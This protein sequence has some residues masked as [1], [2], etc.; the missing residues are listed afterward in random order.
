MTFFNST[1]ANR[2]TNFL[3][4][5]LKLEKLVS[6]YFIAIEDFFVVKSASRNEYFIYLSFWSCDS[7]HRL[8]EPK[9]HSF[10]FNH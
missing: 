6:I 1:K 8:P 9:H 3:L 5:V 4:F 2:N 7:C 10:L